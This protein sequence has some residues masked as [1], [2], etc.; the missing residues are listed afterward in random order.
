MNLS[1]VSIYFSNINHKMK[2][3][4]QFPR[5]FLFH[6]FF[7][8][9]KHKK[10]LF[11]NGHI[12]SDINTDTIKI[13]ISTLLFA[14]CP[15]FHCSGSL[16]LFRFSLLTIICFFFLLLLLKTYS[17]QPR[18]YWIGHF[19]CKLRRTSLSLLLRPINNEGKQKRRKKVA[20]IS[21]NFKFCRSMILLLLTLCSQCIDTNQYYLIYNI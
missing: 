4:I 7:I 11:A 21:F 9:H 8:T 15:L 6:F 5:C 17:F 3:P 19:L 10:K 13:T 12:T 18:F 1:C 20:T 14:L 16:P 2:I